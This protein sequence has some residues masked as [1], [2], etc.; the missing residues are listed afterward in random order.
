MDG[1]HMGINSGKK[2]D[3]GWQFTDLY[4]FQVVSHELDALTKIRDDYVG[5]FKPPVPGEPHPS[6]LGVVGTAQ[7]VA[8]SPVQNQARPGLIIKVAATHA[9]LITR[10]N[11]FYM[12]DKVRAGV[13][14]WTEHY[15][16]PIQIHHNDSP[17]DSHDPIGRVISA[18]YVDTIN[19]VAEVFKNS[20]LRDSFDKDIGRADK[21]FWDT[22]N[23]DR[24][25]FI[26][27]LKMMRM[28]DSVLNDPS[29]EGTGYIELT[30]NIVDPAAIQKILDG[31]Y[32]TGSVGAV[33]D[34]AVCSICDTN[35]VEEEHCGHRPGRIYDGKKCVVVAGNLQYDEWSFVNQ[36]AD[37]HSGVLAIEN[38]TQDSTEGV[39][40]FFPVFRSNDSKEDS[41]NM[42]DE[43]ATAQ[44]K[45]SVTE[46]TT[47]ETPVETQPEAPAAVVEDS[48]TPTDELTV[49]VDKVL[50]GTT[51][52][53]EE[54]D[55]LYELQLEE[56]DK[57]VIEDA[58]LSSEKRKKL[59]SSTFCGPQRSFPVPDC[60]HVTAARRL[61]GKYKG[62]GNK[63][64]IL[65]CVARKAKAFG[66]N[67][68]AVA[69]TPVVQDNVQTQE[70]VPETPVELPEQTLTLASKYKGEIT[71]AVKVETAKAFIAQMIDQ[72]TKDHV[73]AALVDAG[74]T[75]GAAE[76]S[77]LQDSIKSLEEEVVKNED[78]IGEL[79]DQLSALRKELKASYEDMIQV[80]DRLVAA[81]EKS[82]K[83]KV[84]HAELL[85]TLDGTF[86]DDIKTSL[87]KLNDET[88][89]NTINALSAKFDKSKIADRLNSGLSRT[90]DETVNVPAGL[91][92]P[93][94]ETKPT[95]KPTFASQRMVDEVYRRIMINEKNPAKAEAFYQDMV[96]AGQAEPRSKS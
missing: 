83:A 7:P 55:K 27:K 42:K 68:D 60:A 52:T 11:S 86:T 69:E 73:Q 63:D 17:N 70:V 61:I 92:E 56:M 3:R 34:K 45:D 15:P 2:T 25:S 20:V 78:L 79:R 96:K 50:A 10:N 81:H 33:S 58:K 54:S 19:P 22:F 30:A 82:L 41:T 84:Q 21:Q 65:A 40:R 67:T 12:P 43:T 93:T 77:S 91:T 16:K 76:K 71:D 35:W 6:G 66:C 59:A 14:S 9:G 57:G 85:H 88:L 90:P 48:T 75:L 87:F 31:R 37:R 38:S 72:L 89:D 49:L 1:I 36:P 64:E 94:A 4:T 13:A 28:M 24:T 46:P 29:Y 23:S 62:P 44:I 5:A 51:L 18:R 80:E 53:D 8:N 26:Q 95:N 39:I 32:I 47:T 74:F